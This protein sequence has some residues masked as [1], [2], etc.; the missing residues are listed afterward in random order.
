M[1]TQEWETIDSGSDYTTI[2]FAI[3]ENLCA[4]TGKS[5]LCLQVYSTESGGNELIGVIYL[6]TPQ[7]TEVTLK[8][9]SKVITMKTIDDI[10]GM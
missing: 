9:L 5:M 2:D 4:K 1:L 8:L 7:A 6:T 10:R 3:S